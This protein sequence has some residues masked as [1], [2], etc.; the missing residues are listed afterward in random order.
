MKKKYKCPCCL[1]YT[2]DD[3]PPGTFAICHVCCWEDDAI[4]YLNQDYEGGANEMSLNQAR[5]NYKKT[6][7]TS[8]HYIPNDESNPEEEER[9]K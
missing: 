7:G 1:S 5:E 8:E 2:L 4:Q 9:E 6:R 3:E